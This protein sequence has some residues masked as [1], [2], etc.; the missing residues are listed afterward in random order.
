[1][2]MKEIGPRRRVLGAPLRSTNR[3]A[4]Y[5]AMWPAGGVREQREGGV[6]SPSGWYAGMLMRDLSS[7]I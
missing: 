1:M 5:L 2:K 4:G 7:C 3:R 6:K